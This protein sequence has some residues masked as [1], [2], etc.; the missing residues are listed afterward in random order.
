[1][2]WLKKRGQT[3]SPNPLAAPPVQ[4]YNPN[5][6]SNLQTQWQHQD[7][8]APSSNNWYSQTQPNQQSL[9][10][11]PYSQPVLQPNN[12]NRSYIQQPT[13]TYN[14]NPTNQ[15]TEQYSSYNSSYSNENSS[16]QQTNYA[17]QQP[18]N[19]TYNYTQ[20]S[21]PQSNVNT[22]SWNWGWGDE[23]N[24]NVQ[25]LPQANSTLNVNHV[26]SSNEETWNWTVEDSNTNSSDVHALDSH[27]STS[28]NKNSAHQNTQ[29]TA[30]QPSVFPQMGKL[31]EKHSQSTDV[32]SQDSNCESSLNQHSLAYS[33]H[34]TLNQA[35]ISSTLKHNKIDHLTPQWSTESQMSQDSSD[36]LHT[37]E[38]DKSHML[39]RSS[40]I[41]ESPVS[42]H[43]IN[44]ENVIRQESPQSRH[45]ETSNVMTETSSSDSVSMNYYRQDAYSLHQENKE[46]ISGLQEE[47]KQYK[48]NS[49]IP[50]P[51]MTNQTPPHVLPLTD[52]KPKNPY[53]LNTGLSHKSA[54]KHNLEPRQSGNPIHQS[55]YPVSQSPFNQLVNLETLPDNAEQPDTISHISKKVAV[56]P[57]VHQWPDNNEVAPINDRN[58]YLE[59]GQLSNN[60]CNQPRSSSLNDTSDLIPPPGFTRMV[61]GQ[62]EQTDNLGNQ[63]EP[64]PGLSRMVLG[65]TCATSSLPKPDNAEPL[66]RMIPGG[67]SSPKPRYQPSSYPAPKF[68]NTPPPPESDLNVHVPNQIRSATIGADTPSVTTNVVTGAS[69]ANRSM[70][71]GADITM[72][73]S[74]T[75]LESTK[76]SSKVPS[77]SSNFNNNIRETNLE[78]ASNLDE[79]ITTPVVARRDSIEGET[80]DNSVTNLVNSIRDLNVGEN[81]N[82][83]TNSTLPITERNTRRPSKQESTDSEQ[84]SVARDRKERRYYEKHGDYDR[85]RNR[86]Y[87]PSPDR[88]REK[89]YERTRYRD[90]RY[91]DDTDYYSDKDRDRKRDDK[92]RREELDKKYGSLKRDKEKRR[93]E[94]RNYRD[95]GRDGHRK[96][97]YHRYE[98]E[99]DDHSRSRPSSR[100]DSLHDSYR[101]DRDRHRDK[102]RRHRD[103]YNM[104]YMQGYSYD[105]YNPYYQQY[106]YHYLENLRRTNPQAYAEWYRKYY[107]Q[108]NS[109][110]N[111]GNEDRASVHSGRS[112]ANEE[113][114][115]DRYSRQS[116]YNQASLNYYREPHIH[117][118]L[119]HYAPDESRPFDQTD[120]SLYLEDTTGA[121][122]RLTP[123]KFATAH[124]KASISSGRLVKIFPHYPLDGQPAVVEVNN[125]K[126]LLVNDD[127]YKE[128]V[129]FPGPL[130]K[131]V[132]HKKTIIEYC[133]NKIRSAI[134]SRD[135]GDVDSYILMWELLILLLRQN[136]MVVGTDIAELLMKD[137]KQEYS[138]KGSITSN[139]SEVV[140]RAL[141]EPNLHTDLTGS[142]ASILK[143]E[144]V[145]NKFRELLIYGSEK[146]ALE[147]SM[148]HGLW[149]H[150]LFLASKLD[151]RTYANVMTRFANGLTMNDPLQTLYQL[152]SGKIPAS[153]T[154]VSD[155]KWGDWRPHLAMILSNTTQRPELDRKAIMTLGD[156]LFARNSLYAA[157]FSYLMAQVE[158]SR[159][160]TESPKLVL[161]GSNH[162]K[163][164]MEFAINEAIF[165]TEVYE[166]ACSLNDN[167]FVI[168]EFLP[169]KYLLAT[170]L[171]DRGLLDKSLAYL[172]KIAVAVTQNPGLAQ[173]TLIHQV[174]TLG[175][176]L[177][178][179][180]IVE[181]A[182]E[183]DTE[184]D[185][186]PDTTW[187]RDLKAFE[188]NINIH[189]APLDTVE[190]SELMAGTD[191]NQIHQSAYDQ[192]WPQQYAEEQY[193]QQQQWQSGQYDQQ[194][195][196]VYQQSQS[197]GT[198]G[199]TSELYPDQHSYWTHNQLPETTDHGL[200]S[201]TQQQFPTDLQSNSFWNSAPAQGIPQISMPHQSRENA[202][203]D[204]QENVQHQVKKE[205]PIK[206]KAQDKSATT[207]WFGGIWNKLSLRPK[208]QM[209]LPDDK[210]P[211]IVWD[212][213][214]K[215]WINLE[216]EGDGAVAELKPPPKMAD[217][218]SA[219]S[220]AI[221]TIPG[222]VAHDNLSHAPG[223]QMEPTRPFLENGMMP[224]QNSV[225]NAIHTNMAQGQNEV[226]ERHDDGLPKTA[227]PNMFKLQRGR[228]IK[229][230]YVDVFNPGAKSAGNAPS[231]AAPETFSSMP[232]SGLQMNYFVPA[233][234]SDPNAPM[235]FL[236][237]APLQQIDDSSQI[238]R[239][240]SASSLSR[241]VQYYMQNKEPVHR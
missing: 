58:Q 199:Y 241:E 143:E 231:I 35:V 187:L 233:P 22:D 120:S 94:Q 121:S 228:N 151:K 118:I 28:T 62:M 109:Q 236:T 38:S 15:Y 112:S 98:D 41:S 105:P 42:G 93:K 108:S 178:Y 123:A 122:Q 173:P 63:D 204:N 150:A 99:Y 147:W 159:Y 179:C 176:R 1:M 225:G 160:G 193:Q 7:L 223:H 203:R 96:D 92:D 90:P 208:N 182:L 80:Q 169:Y 14:P 163:P 194:N 196:A 48:G 40:T 5:Q 136:G 230:S 24:S 207:G 219:P 21:E 226:H 75:N 157:Q 174:C 135:I 158:F 36:L 43:D 131:G 148:K 132:T 235:D 4:M 140:E 139:S 114:S 237:P 33:D 198:E 115:K 13:N 53:K 8:Q 68:G 78:G 100:S 49:T 47:L 125:L 209:K 192:S 190:N 211:S 54:S 214:K 186:R 129:E 180:D 216:S 6:H 81:L 20:T 10:Q 238:S 51:P 73:Y 25:N 134:Y 27:S 155:E 88:Y 50:P 106:Q 167:N 9:Q 82:N 164:F 76:P 34:P 166:Y 222:A 30:S 146:E 172:E 104:P 71:I 56:K 45:H 66:H 128:L 221:P 149:G 91:D 65:E 39:S 200:D 89:K 156:T 152:L 130:I 232:P 162:N 110:Q 97:Y 16:Y 57:S 240:S 124:V 117:S 142:S 60:E 153:V 206:Q 205:S 85:E 12:W 212:E 119:D 37:S 2:S 11:P 170:R 171:A 127:E 102:Y 126:E 44:S 116:Y 103:P 64:P 46:D 145:T 138:R 107:Q 113:L 195:N 84:E 224:T 227:Q 161:L 202:E 31:A 86:R 19:P 218:Y 215:R 67:S 83:S 77:A 213:Q 32:Y 188:K 101:Q 79:K 184:C 17:N 183:G 52:D 87:S 175:D 70:T 95:Y 165:M 217:M 168:P 18:Q 144:V 137:K 210:N 154:C 234:V 141:S 197:V 229:K 181:D 69:I 72:P 191:Q 111:F 239:S 220:Q 26:E 29:H 61:L 74:S 133:E 55:K 189:S 59:T 177:K 3:A 201:N 23:D 185:N